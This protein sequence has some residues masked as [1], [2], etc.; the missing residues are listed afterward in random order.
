[1]ILSSG[2]LPAYMLCHSTSASIHSSSSATV[3]SLAERCSERTER[4]VWSHRGIG[5]RLLL[6]PKQE[7]SL[8]RWPS[9][10]W[11]HRKL[12]PLP[13]PRIGHNSL[14]GCGRVAC[15]WLHLLAGQAASSISRGDSESSPHRT[16]QPLTNPSDSADYHFSDENREVTPQPRRFDHCPIQLDFS[17]QGSE[18]TGPGWV[19]GSPGK[20]RRH[21]ERRNSARG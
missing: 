5:R 13:V 18:R 14:A 16:L 1:M 17:V 11:H 6:L 15:K 7:G 20:P 19:T 8:S 12:Q 21:S 10:Q 2:I 3:R 4:C 9:T